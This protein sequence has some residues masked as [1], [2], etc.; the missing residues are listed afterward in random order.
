MNY[1][2]DD[3]INDLYG[4]VYNV[5][6]NPCVVTDVLSVIEITDETFSCNL[7]VKQLFGEEEFNTWIEIQAV[8][9]EGEIY[10]DRIK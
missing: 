6:G 9:Y 2:I 1:P 3:I 7:T 10:L 5:D 8:E 4:N